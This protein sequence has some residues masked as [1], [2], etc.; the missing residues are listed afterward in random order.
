MST[1]YEMA[2]KV[3][4][5][6]LIETVADLSKAVDERRELIAEL[7]DGVEDGIVVVA[8]DGGQRQNRAADQILGPPAGEPTE[9]KTTWGFFDLETRDRI[10]VEELPAFRAIRGRKQASAD[11]MA[12]SP[13]RPDSFPL[14]T[15][16]TPLEDGG[17]IVIFREIGERL[18]AESEL[19]RQNGL[20]A[21]RDAEHRDLIERLRLALDELSTPVLQVADGVLVMPIIGV[22][23]RERSDQLAERL[24]EEVV[25]ARAHTVILDVTGVEF[26]DTSNADRFAKLAHG[27]A[28]L[29][30]RCLLSGVQPSVARSLVSL[31]VSL[32]AL[33]PFRNLAAALDSCRPG[34]RPVRT[35][36]K[37]RAT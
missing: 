33:T 32:V 21:V 2:M 14:T 36:R 13:D 29:G 19:E 37:E 8:P 30:A 6:R 25:R 3:E 10:A 15:T 23:D 34:A 18:A 27:V 12:V 28:L 22:L 1:E 31:G 11:F 5:G 7:F 26:M 20:L 4:R 17:A 35:S 9:W 24:L 16:A